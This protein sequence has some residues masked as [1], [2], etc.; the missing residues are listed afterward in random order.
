MIRHAFLFFLISFWETS[1]FFAIN[2]HKNHFCVWSLSHFLNP[3]VV[4]ISD[5][6]LCCSAHIALF[7][8][9]HRFVADFRQCAY[10]L[11]WVHLITTCPSRCSGHSSKVWGHSKYSR[12]IN[13]IMLSTV[14]PS[15]AP[16]CKTTYIES[17]RRICTLPLG[18]S[19]HCREFNF[20]ILVTK[21]YG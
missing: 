19:K 13:N 10:V 3:F 12:A 4:K 6:W 14:G 16:T 8:K 1:S 9:V 17:V 2:P 7:S 21:K 20:R 18:V 5:V 15:V 11:F